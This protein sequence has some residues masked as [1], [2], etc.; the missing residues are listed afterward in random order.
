GTR[1]SVVDDGAAELL[2]A[3][4]GLLEHRDGAGERADL[5]APLPVWHLE[6]RL[7]GRDRLSDV[8]DSRKRSRD[9]APDHDHTEHREQ[10]RERRQQAHEPG[11][12]LDAVINRRVDPLR[13]LGIVLAERLEVGV[14]RLADGAVG[15]VVTPFAPGRRVDLDAAT[16]QLTPELLELLQAPGE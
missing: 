3:A 2:V 9:R 13:A 15:V 11:G 10:Q 6:L 14:E 8:A 7:A 16:N 1:L 5:V 12:P 4:H